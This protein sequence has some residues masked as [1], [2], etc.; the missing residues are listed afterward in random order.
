MRS[1]FVYLLKCSDNTFYT[2]VTNDL[3]RRLEE[4]YKGMDPNCY[5]AKRRPVDL[6]FSQEFV[7][8]KQAISFEKKIKAGEGRR[9]WH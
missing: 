8:V 7:E 3:N 6:V 4:H 1:Y 2:G 9:K 5:T